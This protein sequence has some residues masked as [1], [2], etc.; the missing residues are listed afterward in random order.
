M[1]IN[2]SLE[3]IENDRWDPPSF[4]SGLIIRCY[5]ARKKP[6]RD[7]K[8][9]EIASLISQDISRDI[10]VPIA[11]DIITTNPWV[12]GDF[13]DGELLVSL[14][15]DMNAY[16]TR[17]PD[18]LEKVVGLIKVALKTTEQDEDKCDIRQKLQSFIDCR[19]NADRD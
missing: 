9:C 8:A 13:Y 10:I 12:S 17:H 4:P 2:K 6:I 11:I 18:Q 16:W 7:L 1:D 14:I 19:K 5:E 15:S 3:E